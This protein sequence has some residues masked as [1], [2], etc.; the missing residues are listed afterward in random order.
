MPWHVAE[1][2]LPYLLIH[3]RY[4]RV[5]LRLAV[6][7]ALYI[8]FWTSVLRGVLRGGGTSDPGERERFERYAEA[9]YHGEEGLHYYHLP[10]LLLYKWLEGDLFRDV[11]RAGRVLEVGVDNGV[12]SAL[13][14]DGASFLAGMDYV[15][16]YLLEHRRGALAR[17]RHLCAGDMRRLPFRD[18]AFDT[19]L[20][21]HVIDHADD[22]AATVRE[23]ARVLAPGGRL[24]F[25][26]LTDAYLRDELPFRWWGRL[27]GSARYAA[28][29]ESMCR[30]RHV[31]NTWSPDAWATTLREAGL[32]VERFRRFPALEGNA[33]HAFQHETLAGELGGMFR[34][35][36]WRRGLMHRLLLAA[37]YAWLAP[38]RERESRTGDGGAGVNFFCVA[39]KRAAGD[40]VDRAAP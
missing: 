16:A 5:V 8:Q 36:F 14:F 23:A 12:I 30:V 13:H 34:S 33:W 26:G 38:L 21:A 40:P 39:V 10:R 1:L 37:E 29:L 15:P 35:R 18:G 7:V 28:R 9:V 2:S 20:S 25:S 17:F 31:H 24:V 6:T 4:G 27:L 19:V 11:P 32:T 3:L 22:A